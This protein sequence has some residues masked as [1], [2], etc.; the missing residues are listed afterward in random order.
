[1]R[2]G[3]FWAIIGLL[4]ALVLGISIGINPTRHK[5][6]WTGG[7]VTEPIVYDGPRLGEEFRVWIDKGIL[8]YRFTG[9]DATVLIENGTLSASAYS[10]WHFFVDREHRVWFYSGDIGTYVYVPQSSGY[11]RFLLS[12]QD[13]LAKEMPIEFY[14]LLGATGQQSF[15]PRE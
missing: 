1:M 8:K 11:V 9:S 2:K 12:P 7:L 3:F 15:G 14:K 4:L 6:G 5:V 13:Q 10:R